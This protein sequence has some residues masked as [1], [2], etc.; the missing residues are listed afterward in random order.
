MQGR[1]IQALISGLGT[2]TPAA[3]RTRDLT[4]R[5]QSI[6]RSA[7]QSFGAQ[8][9]VLCLCDGDHLGVAARWATDEGQIG[10]EELCRVPECSLIAH[11]R[12]TGVPV[13][14]ADVR[15]IGD[16]APYSSGAAVTR[17]ARGD[18]MSVLAQPIRGEAD[19]VL[20]VLELV[21]ARDPQ[22]AP[23][24]FP[25][26]A[27]TLLPAFSDQAASAILN[28]R[29]TERLR[30]AQFDT[31][32]RLSVAAEFRDMDTALHIQRMSRYSGVIARHLGLGDAAIEL[33]HLASPMHDVGKLAIPD[34]VLLKAGPLTA[35]EWQ[36][37]R[38]HPAIGAQIIGVSDSLLL[39]TAHQVALAHH[40]K[41]DGSG[42]PLEA[43]GEAIPLLARIAALGDAFD[44]ITSPRRYKPARS[45]EEGLC[46]VTRDAGAHFDP[47]CVAALSRGFD[48]ALEIH[49]TF[50]DDPP[51]P[52]H[53][54]RATCPQ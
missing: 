15:Q 29:L 36:I 5:L 39:R 54:P 9:A 8:M 45:L 35:D 43:R 21:D 49:S 26:M 10:L 22:G 23:I 17:V 4:V 16:G 50:S 44:A 14:I 1:D 31:V 25:P 24:P 33:V 51:E 40:E 27:L 41:I 38:M 3:P 12:D 6:V 34:S 30:E 28:A 7:A 19:E 32:F 42:Y 11:A 2:I 52:D 48:E 13:S 18:A 37:M 46:V 53:S 20:G 47:E